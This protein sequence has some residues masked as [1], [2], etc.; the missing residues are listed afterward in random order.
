MTFE[1]LNEK[2]KVIQTLKTNKNGEVTS[3]DLP[4][5]E[6]YTIRE[7]K[8]L[9]NYDITKE[10][11]TITLKENEISEL[12]FDNYKGRGKIEIIKTSSD[13]KVEGFSFKIYGTSYTGEYFESI[14]KTDENG[15]ILI[16]NVLEGNY[17]IEEVRDEISSAY[18]ELPSQNVEVKNGETT[19]V[20]FFNK[21]IEVPKTGDNSH[22]AR[23]AGAIFFAILGII[24]I[25]IKIFKGKK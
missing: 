4:I 12:K 19:Q 25:I 15:H 17:T 13:G 16:E 8:T 20:S 10:T 9:E 3:I 1:V 5:S 24:Y 23:F 21:L 18:E 7:T 14:F 22:I 6:K 2:G 11:K